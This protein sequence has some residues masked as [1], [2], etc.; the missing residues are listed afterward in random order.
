MTFPLSKA[1]IAIGTTNV[2]AII[3]P[4]VST[5][6]TATL[7]FGI[8]Y[9]LTENTVRHQGNDQ[10][11]GSRSHYRYSYLD[12]KPYNLISTRPR[13]QDLS[14]LAR[15]FIAFFNWSTVAVLYAGRSGD[16]RMSLL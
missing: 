13:L 5:V 16:F 6:L 7:K 11:L 2:S 12:E 1:Y 10:E 15:D 9:F 3:G 4:F 8:P 14:E